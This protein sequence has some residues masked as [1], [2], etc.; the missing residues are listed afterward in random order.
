M[1]FS[2]I[3]APALMGR[4]VKGSAGGETETAMLVVLIEYNWPE[5]VSNRWRAIVKIQ[6]Y[7]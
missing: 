5:A 3:S 2:Y 6:G 7:Y 1:H 4:A